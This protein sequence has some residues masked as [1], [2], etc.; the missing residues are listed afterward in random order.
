M[1]LRLNRLLLPLCR[2]RGF[3]GRSSPGRS[4]LFLS[5]V[6]LPA[7]WLLLP[8]LG[9]LVAAW[10]LLR[11]LGALVAAWLLPWCPG[12]LVAA[13]LPWSLLWLLLRVWLRV[14]LRAWLYRPDIP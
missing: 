5:W 10:L 14:W 4:G 11:L 6:A 13:L 12:A 9:V 2:S 3:V 8:V 1:G 7:A